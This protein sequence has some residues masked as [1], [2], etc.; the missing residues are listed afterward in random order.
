[1]PARY[2]RGDSAA[3]HRQN[4]RDRAQA[5]VADVMTEG[6]QGRA[7]CIGVS[8]QSEQGIDVGADE[9]GPDCALVVAAVVVRASPS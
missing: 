7:G 1:M 5:A 9:P 3:D 6:D 4:L 2:T 8:A